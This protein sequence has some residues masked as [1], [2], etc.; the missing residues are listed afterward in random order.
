MDSLFSAHVLWF[1]VA[2]AFLLAELAMPGFVL[3]FFA[4]GALAAALC[5]YLGL[6]TGGQIAVF[7]LASL[8]GIVLLR[9]MFLR[10]FRGRTL[11][12]AGAGGAE[13]PA[14]GSARAGENFAGDEDPGVGKLALVTRA[15]APGVPGEIKFRGSFWRAEAQEQIGEGENVVITGLA[16]N[17]SGAYLVRPAKEA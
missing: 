17:D 5:A 3:L 14:A 4:L 15:M 16:Q 6:G 8:A 13:H 9:R 7:L 2:T 10:V 12:A 11:A 1:L